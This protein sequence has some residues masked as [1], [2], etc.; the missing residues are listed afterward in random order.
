[1]QINSVSFKYLFVILWK[2]TRPFIYVL[3]LCSYV[4][5]CNVCD[6]IKTIPL[7]LFPHCIGYKLNV[8]AGLK[9]QSHLLYDTDALLLPHKNCINL[10]LERKVT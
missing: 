4:S 5:L 6:M 3:T 1:M 8:L 2:A 7:Q 10:K 9:S